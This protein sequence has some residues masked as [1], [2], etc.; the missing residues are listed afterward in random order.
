MSDFLPLVTGEGAGWIGHWSPGIG[1]PT[2]AGWIA[3][4]A[5]VAA[6]A[7]CFAA[8]RRILPE[9]RRVPTLR[10]ER[11]LW[12]ALAG[13]LAALGVNKQLDLQTALTELG[14]AAA[15]AGGWYGQ[16][17]E[18]Q[19]AFVAAVG[20]AALGAA[21]LALWT[22]RRTSAPVRVA[23]AGFVALLGFV[24]ARAASFHHFDLA[25]S[26]E[27]HGLR[28]GS[29]VEI[30][31]LAVLIAAAQWQGRVLGGGRSEGI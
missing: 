23:C 13:A 16:R 17:R 20:V 1:D 18:V 27:W 28:V 31:A 21:A 22:T 6:A 14:R 30:G 11:I 19:L 10:R 2:P 26:G 3:T 24:V 29:L 5:Y 25:I 12:H 7:C 15:R 4:L 9:Y 8:G